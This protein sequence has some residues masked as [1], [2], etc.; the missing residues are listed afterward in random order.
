MSALTPAALQSIIRL[1]P[2]LTYLCLE[3]SFNAV[4]D[5]TLKTIGRVCKML[6]TACF[7]HC[8]NIGD[9]GLHDL[10]NGCNRLTELSIAHCYE[11]SSTALCSLA[12]LSHLEVLSLECN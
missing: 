1:N 4:N 5:E 11:I 6:R 12:K 2:K 7:S 10:V 3:R 9:D 8:M